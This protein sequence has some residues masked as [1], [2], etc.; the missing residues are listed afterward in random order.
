L[1]VLFFGDIMGRSGRDALLAELPGLTAE[2]TPDFI[3]VNG[4][5]A[6]GGF[7]LTSEIANSLFAGGVDCIT[8][9][10][11]AWDQRAL[12]SEIDHEPR[13][14]R[15]LNSPPGTPGKGANVYR[16]KTGRTLLV[17]N[18]MGRLFMDALD[19]PFQSVERE[20]AKHRLGSTVDG[21][22]IDFHAEAS[23][24]KMAL[25]HYVDGRA[26]LVVGTHTHIPTADAQILPGGTAYQTDAGMCGDYDSVIGVKKEISVHRFVRKLPGDRMVPADGPATVAGVFVE[27]DPKTGLAIAIRPIRRGGRLIETRREEV[28]AISP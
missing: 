26:S 12:L 5:N 6:A 19:D 24:E 20:L 25:A 21:I 10:N 9:G 22:L 14:L 23:S 28:A 16:S 17:M 18:P 4:E 7:G 1:K 13:I 2:M 8:T 27:T 3:V 15:P 11:H